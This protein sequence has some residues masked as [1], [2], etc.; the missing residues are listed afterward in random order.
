MI[1]A[2]TSRIAVL[3][4]SVLTISA[5]IVL[6]RHNG[7]SASHS[8]SSLDDISL[9][10]NALFVPCTDVADV[11]IRVRATRPTH[12]IIHLLDSHFLSREQ[13][14]TFFK[15]PSE[16]GYT[17]YLEAVDR[18]QVVQSRILLWLVDH[19]SMHQVFLEGMSSE[20]RHTFVQWIEWRRDH[21]DEAAGAF[22]AATKLRSELDRADLR[23]TDTEDVRRRKQ[24]ADRF[25]DAILIQG[26]VG[27]LITERP[28]VALMP[29]EDEEA[30]DRA[31]NAYREGRYGGPENASREEALVHN[32]LQNGRCAV[33]VLGHT[34][35]LSDEIRLLGKGR[36]EYVRVTPKQF[37]QM[38]QDEGR[39]TWVSEEGNSMMLN[40]R[41]H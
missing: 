10:P 24:V 1:R 26:A 27:R 5:I 34:H 31:R 20:N 41:R 13:Y 6:R 35:D 14:R 3:V 22:V 2:K 8:T 37:P 21:K 12:R 30:H 16:E 28:S 40:E 36:C 19:H 7:T 33:V 11:E 9:P 38:I 29:A 39:T 17:E 25:R 4:A 18:L 23:G 15:P 32:L